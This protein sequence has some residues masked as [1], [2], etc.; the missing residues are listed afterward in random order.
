MR[1]RNKNPDLRQTRLLNLDQLCL[2]IGMGKNNARKFAADAEAVRK[3]GKSVRYDRKMIDHYLD[4][5]T[6]ISS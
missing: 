1:E 6:P 4:E 5:L 3:F 2:Y